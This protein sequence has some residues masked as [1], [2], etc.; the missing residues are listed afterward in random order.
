MSSIHIS[1]SIL[2][3]DF[4]KLGEELHA[5]EKSGAQSLHIDIMDGHFVPK[6][7]FGPDLIKTIRP[8][9][10]LRLDVHLMAENTEQL[11]EESIQAG[12]QR[13]FIHQEISAHVYRLLQKIRNLDASPAIVICPGTPAI[14][15][16]ELFDI[17]DSILVMTV[18]PGLGGQKF[19]D[20]QLSKIEQINHMIEASQRPIELAVDGGI[21]AKTAPRVV[22]AGARN[23]IAGSAVFKSDNYTQAVQKLLKSCVQ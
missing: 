2:A 16:S 3:A 5:I 20:N 9:C 14:M 22:R 1:P 15:L 23:L 21:N 19:L 4:S 7:S 10:N 17:V 12:G 18:N 13:I 11:I 8:Y 6:I